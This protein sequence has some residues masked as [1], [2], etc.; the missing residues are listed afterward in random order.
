MILQSVQLQR[1]VFVLALA[2]ATTGGCSSEEAPAREPEP[3][4]EQT[5]TDPLVELGDPELAPFAG[6]LDAMRERRVVRALVAPSRTDFFLDHGRIRGLQAELLQALEKHLNAGRTRES[7]RIRVKHVPVAFGD[8]IPALEEGRG[9]IAAAFLTQT[10]E[11]S[12]RA[13]FVAGLREQVSE[14]VVTHRGSE[15]PSTLEDLSGRRLYVLKGSSYLDH[16]RDLNARL[17]SAGRPPVEVEEADARLEGEDI[18]ELV[19]SG[20]VEITIVDDYKA[21]LWAEVLP[22]I[23]LREDLPLATG[24]TVGWAVRRDSPQLAS[25]LEQ[26]TRKTRS[27]T[28]LGNILFERYFEKV[29]WI[30]DPTA[31][32]E[33]DRLARYIDLFDEYANRY[34]FEPLAVAAQAYQESR[35]DHSLRSPRGAVGLMQVLPTTA[36]DPNVGIPDIEDAETNIHAG[37]KYLA[38]LRDRYF[39]DPELDGWNRTAFALAA[40]NAGPRKIREARAKT[41]RMGLDPNQWFD[42]V[43]VATGRHVGREPVRYVANIYKYYV[44]YRL[45][46]DR[47]AERGRPF[48]H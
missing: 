1:V 5:R 39:S 8:L 24:R 37:T 43:E 6:D 11:R 10:P 16:L 47:A 30:D 22:D 14:I 46:L 41:A 28:L 42:N 9:D 32:A 20:V 18:L 48:T 3:E 31:R 44:A 25:E 13:H 2:L 33:R 38:F 23:E 36:R 7:V 26:F 17:R 12:K 27:G 29:Q 35:L 45:L 34:G 40:Y 19:N 21:R 15:R 4:P